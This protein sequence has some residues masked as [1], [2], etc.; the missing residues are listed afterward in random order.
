MRTSL[1]RELIRG[2]IIFS[3]IYRLIKCKPHH[4]STRQS[5]H[6]IRTTGR[7][8]AH[9]RTTGDKPTTRHATATRDPRPDPHG[10]G[11]N[12]IGAPEPAPYR[13]QSAHHPV[14][15]S[16]CT[17]QVQCVERDDTCARVKRGRAA[18]NKRPVLLAPRPR[19]GATHTPP[20]SCT[21]VMSPRPFI[22]SLRDPR[23]KTGIRVRLG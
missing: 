5:P 22:A 6:V 18:A 13:I 9:P 20:Q 19:P 15:C 2:D 16:S 11:R 21:A 17:L 14:D 7:R 10:R 8:A 23:R 1:R 12:R 3:E 4:N